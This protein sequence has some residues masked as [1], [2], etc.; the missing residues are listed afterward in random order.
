MELEL[1]QW[2]DLLGRARCGLDRERGSQVV[3]RLH[4]AAERAAIAH[5]ERHRLDELCAAAREF[6]KTLAPYVTRRR[7]DEDPLIKSFRTRAGLPDGRPHPHR[8]LRCVPIGWTDNDGQHSPWLDVLFAAECMSQSARG[9]TLKDTKDW[10]RAARDAYTKLSAG[11]VSIDLLET[12]EPLRVPE[13]GT[14]DDYTRGKIIRTAYWYRRLREGR[15]RVLER[16]PAVSG[17]EFNPDAEHPRILAAVREIESWTLKR[18]KVLVF[19]VFLRP[20]RLLRDVL[21]V[22][23]ALRAADAGRPVAH[24]VQTDLGLLG[25]ALRQLERLR[26]EEAF[27]GR[28]AAGNGAAMRRALADSRKTYERLRR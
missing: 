5:D 1:S 13:P 4:N 11:H 2:L 17:V 15:K 25:I 22:R 16:L 7:R 23:Y 8:L 9:L 26:S 6:T 20:L 10:P 12:S 19:G 18:E 14:V 27:T 21:N 24:A 3:K 28:L